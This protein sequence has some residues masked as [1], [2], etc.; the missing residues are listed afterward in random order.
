MIQRTDIFEPIEPMRAVAEAVDHL[1]D[2]HGV[3]NVTS[4]PEADDPLRQ[5]TSWLPDGVRESQFT[6]I[7]E[8]FRGT[9]VEALLRKL[10]F[11]FGRTRLLKMA[12][13][14]CLSIHWDTSRRWH[15][16]ITTNPSC[17]L[18]HVDGEVGHF[19]HIPADGYLYEMDARLTHTAI[20]ASKEYRLHLVISDAA[21]EGLREG[22][23]AGH[24]Y[25]HAL[26]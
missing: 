2:R 8:P 6:E 16:A 26:A 13:K 4:R 17:Y 25:R 14:S 9:A 12:P 19:H 21:D 22:S 10:P 5:H 15:Y 7:N 23:P 3:L 11:Q 18:I 20:N 1:F 24:A